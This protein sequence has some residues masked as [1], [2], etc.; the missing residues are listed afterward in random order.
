VHNLNNLDVDLPRDCLVV[1]TGVS[2][3][4]KSSLAFDT[5][6]AEGQRRYLECVSSHARQF[7]DQLERPDVDAI[8][9]LPPT[10]AI[11]QRP[12]AANPRSTLGTIT[13]IHDYLRLLFAR[14]GVPHC[15]SCGTPIRRKTPEQMV[16][17]LMTLPDGKRVQL[18]APLV[19]DRRGQHLEV[20][21]AIRRAGL[22]RAR[23]DGQIIE[24]TEAPPKLAKTG[25]HTIEA[26]VDRLAIREGIRP[27]LA[28]SLDLA[29]RLSGGNVLAVIEAPPAWDEE[30][31][32]IHLNCPACGTSLPEIEL[33]S[34]SFNSPHGACPICQGLGSREAFRPEL[35]VPDRSRSWDEGAVVPW[36][37]LTSG[38]N[39]RGQTAREAA[40]QDFLAQHGLSGAA[41][42]ASWP[43]NAFDAFWRGEPGGSFPGIS[44]LL[45]D[46]SQ[47]TRS[48]AL[49]RA[50]AAYCEEVPCSACMGSR[51]R[52]EAR[53]VRLGGQSIDG[54]SAMAIGDLINFFRSLRVD[55][56]Q[57]PI[58]A[59]LVADI[60]GRLQYLVDV[61]LDYLSLGRG[62]DTLSGGELQR[63]RLASQLGSGLAGVC[64]ILDEPTAGLHPHDTGRLIASL[65][66]LREL[67]NS[68]LV[69]EH[70]RSVIEAADWV[71]DLGPG[72]GP[73]GGTVVAAGPPSRLAAVRTSIT[74]RYLAQESRR[75]RNQSGRERRESPRGWIQ[76]RRVAVH[77][78]KHVDAS[79][80]VGALTCVTGVSGSG[81]SS[82]VHDVLARA[83]RRALHRSGCLG[84][85]A[86]ELA[87]VQEPGQ[88]PEVEPSTML[89]RATAN[90][91]LH[92]LIDR[93]VEVD[94][95]PI[96]RTPRSIP[97]TATGLLDE[98]RRVFAATREARIRGF[99]AG[100]F[101]FNASEGRCEV[102]RGLG[103]R[104][105]PMQFLPDLEVTCDECGGQRFNRQTL[106]VR[107]KGKSIGD[108]L[109][110]RVD[111]GRAFFEGV[112]KVL[113]GLE[114]LRDVGLEY[115]TLGQSSTTL[116]GGEAQRVRLAAEL[117]RSSAGRTLYIL[118]EPT[119]GLHLADVERLLRILDRLIDLG[120]T[121]VVVEHHLDVIASADW[122]IDLG[123]GGG[124]AGGS[125][126]MMGPPDAI[127]ACEASRTGQAL[128]S[129][130]L[131]R[132]RTPGSSDSNVPGGDQKKGR[133]SPE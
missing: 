10:V 46:A 20:F 23:V 111:E 90:G 75:A 113:Q 104:R 55:P 52:P 89:S 66:R 27:R 125:V 4:G 47:Q 3:S 94:Q 117:G 100:R 58:T 51:L 56:S 43:S 54:L 61:G 132:V 119:M 36:L 11:D 127:A 2:G 35:V 15:P 115:V 16:A 17:R 5:I 68:I 62:S 123:P 7:L 14:A 32:S 60:A 71:V 88:S 110:M 109:E 19:R 8:D 38:G 121:V 112:P 42:I 57:E 105:I 97:A 39:D 25:A 130:G 133:T 49:R 59:P 122:V 74:G 118:D 37:L 86:N 85:L 64:Y 69:V 22:I 128:C 70:D 13:E 80:P 29:L 107:F 41:A 9:G 18:L 102:C 21:D 116:S 124:P 28:E 84:T 76:I 106:E 95:S 87:I 131:V 1:L 79:I 77:N 53:A 114:A 126:V 40:V 93:L 82:L 73:D 78:L 65:S 99:G 92:G 67:G 103:R 98:I 96:G 129:S 48:E 63:A 12:G 120:H 30:F 44:V 108:V 24:V 91:A 34:F 50:L 101:S 72:A 33:R 45:E 26:V 81:K 83:L 6:Y 31:L